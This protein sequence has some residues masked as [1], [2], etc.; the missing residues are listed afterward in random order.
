M[1]KS[2]L[3]LFFGN[4][5]GKLVGFFREIILAALYGISAPVGAF[6][7]AQSAT[8]IPVNFF[9]SDSLNAGFIP[10]Y[11]RY[12]KTSFDKAQSLFWIL[13]LILTLTSIAISIILFISAS[14]W[15]TLLAP[16]FTPE[17]HSLAVLFVKI[18]AIGIP[19]Y[20]LSSLYSYLAIANNSYLLASIRPALQSLGMI[21][22][23][24]LA[25]YFNNIALFAWG[26]TGAYI[27]FFFFGIKELVKQNLFIFS[28]YNKKEI[29]N[30]FWIIIKP[31][32]LLSILL[33]GN[34]AIE[35]IVS[36]YLGI[37][38]VASVEYA[39]FITETGI[40]LLAV[41][42]GLVGLSTLSSMNA[43]ETKEKL[44]QIIPLVIILTVPVSLFLVI[45]S[46]LIISLIFKRGAFTQ[47]AVSLTHSVLIGLSIGF[48]AQ[49]A[50]YVMI[51][52][53][54]AH[55]RNK[56]VVIF[57]SI[58]LSANALFNIL[59]YKILG[60]ITIGIGASIYG[61]ILFVF[62]INAL[63]LTKEVLSALLW[64]SGGSVIYYAINNFIH[65]DGWIG[66]IISVFI[67]VFYWI[68]YVMAVPTLRSSMM[69]L[70]MKL[71]GKK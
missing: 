63:K 29:L 52:A 55:H 30:D 42:L 13:K 11:N 12:K 48:W 17:G 50:S 44:L 71:K 6:R 38:V 34:I 28:F 35:R 58:A 8:L 62:T 46:E 39:R 49:V 37:E 14:W 15:I 43:K 67:F 22:G 56:E 45:N 40:V 61:F 3:K 65:I 66:I 68:V 64:L 60:P 16:G 69:P 9:T 20:I 41:P 57:M 53:L 19:F 32:L 26:F 5:L 33:Q 10:L 47:D 54:N 18:M 70:V 4:I 21:C 59:F 1:L 23:I 25:Y 27:L 31:L 7:I 51:K 2:F 36:S 24:S